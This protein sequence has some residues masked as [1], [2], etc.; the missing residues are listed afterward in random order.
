MGPLVGMAKAGLA[1]LPLVTRV[2]VV[3]QAVA[4]LAGVLSPY[5][6]DIACLQP[7]KTIMYFQLHRLW[8]YAILHRNLIHFL[9][10]I[11]VFLAVSPRLEAAMGSFR[12][13]HLLLVLTGVV[14]FVY[15][16]GAALASMIMGINFSFWVICTIG[17][18][19]PVV[20][21]AVIE[22]YC[23][24]VSS[25]LL[26]IRGLEIPPTILP[27]IMLLVAEFLPTTS[28]WCNFTGVA[29]G[30]LYVHGILQQLIQLS[31]SSV[32]ILEASRF[33]RKLQSWSSFVACPDTTTLPTTIALPTTIPGGDHPQAI[34]AR[35]F[36][37]SSTAT[38]SRKSSRSVSVASDS[39]R[40][41]NQ[42]ARVVM[43][44]TFNV[45]ITDEEDGSEEGFQ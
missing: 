32:H 14:A 42:P 34:P 19:S 40:W 38:S 21:L 1:A 20:C 23:F 17:L 2:V 26:T 29:V 5:L 35:V 22:I 9:M 33:G 37:S 30:Y 8:T 39:Q 11:A 15:S 36:Q 4:F 16:L 6:V 7:S 28:F 44:E 18:T 13:G 12:Y 27:P 45:P 31:N 10:D 41:Q 24:S 43:P 25:S 3:F